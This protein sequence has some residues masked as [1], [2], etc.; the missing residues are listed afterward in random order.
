MNV[1]FICMIV[2]D[3]MCF[4]MLNLCW[5]KHK[6]IFECF[7]CFWKVF[8]SLK[9]WK[10]SKTVLPCFGD[11]VA[12]K[13]SR[14]PQSQA[15]GSILVTC[16]WV[17]GPVARGTQRFSRLSSLLP[18]EWDFQSRKTLSKF[19]KTFGLKCFGGCIWRLPSDLPL[20]RKTRVLHS[21][22]SF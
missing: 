18:C 5:F 1:I 15:H 2:L 10:F 12:G 16:S 11:S 22:G 13:S 9:N 8:C 7:S 4:H 6:K 19:F 3:K 14:M 21:K 17:E 20:P